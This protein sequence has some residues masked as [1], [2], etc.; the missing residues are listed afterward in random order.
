MFRAVALV[1]KLTGL[2]FNLRPLAIGEQQNITGIR[3]RWLSGDGPFRQG[4]TQ[5]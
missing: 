3:D 5:G 1:V 4:F 2:I